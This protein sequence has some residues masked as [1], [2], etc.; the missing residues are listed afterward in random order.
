M[1]RPNGSV[2]PSTTHSGVTKGMS[3]PRVE[4]DPFAWKANM[5]NQAHPVPAWQ[6]S[7]CEEDMA[8]NVELTLWSPQI[9]GTLHACSVLVKERE[10]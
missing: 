5:L 8:K 2:K 6:K 4:L 3:T 7:G 9:K 1:G 10:L